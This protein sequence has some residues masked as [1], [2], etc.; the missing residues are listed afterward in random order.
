MSHPLEDA[1]TGDGF[2]VPEIDL[3]GVTYHETV[4]LRA[5][6]FSPLIA[7]F[8]LRTVPSDEKASNLTTAVVSRLRPS[9]GQPLMGKSAHKSPDSGKDLF[10]QTSDAF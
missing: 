10:N 1:G 2:E 7:G 6:W 4:I 8:V 3:E 5:S 9:K